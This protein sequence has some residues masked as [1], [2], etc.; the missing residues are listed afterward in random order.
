[1]AYND[2]VNLGHNVVNFVLGTIS[3]Y[4][5]VN[6]LFRNSIFKNTTKISLTITVYLAFIFCWALVT[7]SHFAYM[8]ILW[9]P[10]GGTYD[11]YIMYFTGIA[12]FLF[13]TTNSFVD[14]FLC[15]ERGI[16][17][18]F[19]FYFAKSGNVHFAIITMIAI[20]ASFCLIGYI[21]D[22]S[23]IFPS[24]S[25]TLCQF[26]GCLLTKSLYL[27]KLIFNG[28]NI[29]LAIILSFL[30][31]FK[32]KTNSKNIR[33]MSKTVAILL[34]TSTVIEFIPIAVG[35]IFPIVCRFIHIYIID[36]SFRYL[37]NL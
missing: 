31:K 13:L 24:N 11:A 36:E 30:I 2:Y 28:I 20:L 18:L 27:V 29:I 14:V 4:C 6:M 3:L 7:V 5:T 17:I 32:L 37:V 10:G 35:Q 21:N 23:G 8:L 1:M 9:R 15:T 26:F 33:R 25:F 19:P 34:A 12:D 16:A 22:F